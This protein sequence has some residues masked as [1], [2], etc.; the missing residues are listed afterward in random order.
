MDLKQ[1]IR[2]SVEH[3]FLPGVSLWTAPDRFTATVSACSEDQLGAEKPS[4]SCASFLKSSE[5]A[6]QQ[7]ELERR[8]RRW[9]ASL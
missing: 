8:F 4:A 7:W 2:T 3:A 6:Q 9:E 5:K 1:M